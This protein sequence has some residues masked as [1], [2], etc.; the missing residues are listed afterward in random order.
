[1]GKFMLLL[2]GEP[3]IDPDLFLRIKQIKEQFSESIV[4]FTSNFALADTDKI[5]GIIESGLDSIII[6][7]NST[8]PDE[9]RDLMRLD[10]YKTCS[11]IQMLISEKKKRSSNLRIRISAVVQNGDMREIERMQQEWGGR[12]LILNLFVSYQ[13]VIMPYAVLT[14]KGLSDLMLM[15]QRSEII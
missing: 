3:L 2:N 1:M 6:S 14:Q 15:T 8:D 11:N 5:N 13:M 10:Y 7:L 9:Y 12:M 4:E